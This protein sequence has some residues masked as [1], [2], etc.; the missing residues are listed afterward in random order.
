M[1]RKI[2]KA[3]LMNLKNIIKII[4]KNID[5]KK[6][7]IILSIKSKENDN[8]ISLSKDSESS[9]SIN[10]FEYKNKINNESSKYILI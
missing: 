9:K 6:Y 7:Q 3:I 8:D 5:L 2:K 1:I 10:I 4:I